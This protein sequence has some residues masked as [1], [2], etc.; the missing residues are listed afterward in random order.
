MKCAEQDECYGRDKGN[1]SEDINWYVESF[2][3]CVYILEEISDHWLFEQADFQKRSEC[4]IW[5]NIT[6]SWTLW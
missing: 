6:C 2:R 5:W 3:Y 4:R 1:H